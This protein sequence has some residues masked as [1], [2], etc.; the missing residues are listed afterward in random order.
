MGASRRDPGHV[1]TLSPVATLHRAGFPRGVNPPAPVQSPGFEVGG[2]ER[3]EVKRMG[4]HW[5]EKRTAK[6]IL[7]AELAGRGWTIHGYKA[8]ESDAMTDYYAPADWDGLAEK[9]D[10]VLVVDMYEAHP[11]G[12]QPTKHVPQVS[13]PCPRCLG[14]K[15]DPEGWTYQA[16]LDDPRTWNKVS[17]PEGTYSLMP[18]VV[19]PLHFFGCGP[20][21][22]SSSYDAEDH[23]RERCRR[24]QGSGVTY[25]PAKEEPKGPRWP[26]HMA[27]PKGVLWHIEK[28]GKIVK[29]GHKLYHIAREEYNRHEPEDQAGETVCT[30]C[31]KEGHA[32]DIRRERCPKK[33]PK[34]QALLDE[35]DRAAAGEPVPPPAGPVADLEVSPGLRPGYVEIRFQSK[36]DEAIRDAL[37]A[38]GFRWARQ[39]ACWYGLAERLPD[40]IRGGVQ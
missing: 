33:T 37:K 27:S 24:C 14:L 2:L 25:G 22:D 15:A 21:G 10:V 16:A 17:A 11:D 26:A 20:M 12:Y 40:A 38:A 19:S 8:D 34:L 29:R 3:Y 32:Y 35:I 6:A 31:G 13:G 9:G 39:N 4:T 7:G 23:G 18:D 5:T 1:R 36:P 28:G 30:Q